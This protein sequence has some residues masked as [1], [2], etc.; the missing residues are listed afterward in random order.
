TRRPSTRPYPETT[1]SPGI[2]CSAIPKSRQRWSTSLSS[3][4]KVPSSSR[5]S[6]RSRAVSLPSACWRSRRSAP[7][8]SSAW[9]IF[10]RRV[11]S[12]S[13]TSGSVAATASPAAA[14]A[15]APRRARAPV[16][17]RAREGE[18]GELLLHLRAGAVGTGHGFGPGPD[19]LLEPRVAE[20]AAVLVEGHGLP[21]GFGADVLLGL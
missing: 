20:R 5:S 17:A 1:P 15:A 2:R 18:G 4:S 21:R 16:C 13:L 11:A 10:S 9:R 8:P 3:S 6:T 19:E 14:P 7:P 12:R